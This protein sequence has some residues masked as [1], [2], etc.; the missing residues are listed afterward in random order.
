MF[1]MLPEIAF[2]RTRWAT[3]ALVLMSRE[4]KS[5]IGLLDVDGFRD[6]HLHGAKLRSQDARRR[7]VHRKVFGDFSDLLFQ[8]I[9]TSIVIENLFHRVADFGHISAGRHAGDA[10]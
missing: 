4:R 7:I 1:A 10:L 6:G 2:S 3:R 9:V 5:S 8:A